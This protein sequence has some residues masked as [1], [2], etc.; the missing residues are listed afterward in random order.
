MLI[1]E[2]KD[3]KSGRRELRNFG[4]SVGIVVMLL[5]VLLWYFERTAWVY[6][7]VIGAVLAVLGLTVPSVL[8][9]LQK[10]W[11]TLAV[12]LGWFMTRLILSLTFYL[13]F[14]PIKLLGLLTGRKFLE[15]KPDKNQKSYWQYRR[16]EEFNRERYE[17]QF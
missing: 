1:E 15:M 3:I 11:M 4:L 14:T 8:R 13:L 2:I 7:M 10:I 17:K 16:Q 5:S 9:P 6:L 12:I